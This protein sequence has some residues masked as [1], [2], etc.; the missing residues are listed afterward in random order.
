MVHAK[1]KGAV[2]YRPVLT[3]E[4]IPDNLKKHYKLYQQ[5]KLN[6]TDLSK[7]TGCSRTTSYVHI[8]LLQ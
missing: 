7:L 5:D 6:I 2:I 8:K 4:S 3:V 1:T